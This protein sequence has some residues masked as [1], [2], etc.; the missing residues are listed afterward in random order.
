M[1]HPK[2]TFKRIGPGVIT[3]ASDDD[4]SGIATYSQAGAQ[5]GYGLLWMALFTTPMMMAVQEMSARLGLVSGQGLAAVFRKHTSVKVVFILSS[6][7]FLVNTINIGADLSAMAA[8]VQLLVPASPWVYLVL[9]ALGIAVL[10]VFVSYRRYVN[11][12]RWLTLSLLAYVAAA[13]FVQ[14][15]WLAVLKQTIV[16]TLTFTP[17]SLTMVVAVLGTTISPYLFFWQTSEEV[18]EE[19]AT[20][21][22]TVRA[23]RGATSIELKSMRRDVA[24][25]MIFSNVIMFFIIVMSAATLHRAGITNIQTAVQA[26]EALRPL[27]ANFA[28]ILFTLGIVGTG[29]L[30]IPILA[31]SASYAIAEVFGWREGLSENYRHAHS[32]Y[33]VMVV[34]IALGLLTNALGVPPISF[35]VFAAVLNGLLAPI[36]LWYIIRLADRR[37]IVGRRRSPTVVRL[38]GWATFTVIALATVALVIQYVV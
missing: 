17:A 27:T 11:V 34:A 15:D 7:L 30:A 8:A 35:L 22:K 1:F 29:L 16:P 5:F 9:F 25:G 20:G 4:P 3:G 26:A 14:Q 36:F 18:E 28:F 19:I 10:E 21:R 37:D 12:L 23:R 6:L 38:V 24:A 2:K 32:F 31:A 33:L 13:F